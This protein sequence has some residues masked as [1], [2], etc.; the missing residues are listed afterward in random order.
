MS[1]MH[2]I[3]SVESCMEKK[4]YAKMPPDVPIKPPILLLIL[5]NSRRPLQR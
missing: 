5:M 4:N 1:I 2:E 3:V